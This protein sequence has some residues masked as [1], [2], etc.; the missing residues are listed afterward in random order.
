MA[1]RLEVDNPV[2][3]LIRIKN[4]DEY[5]ISKVIDDDVY[6]R[7]CYELRQ[8]LYSSRGM[9]RNKR[10]A[11]QAQ[12]RYSIPVD[13]FAALLMAGDPDALAWQNDKNDRAALHRMVA[14]FPHWKVAG[15]GC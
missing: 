1:S 7:R 11:A 4:G 3:T 8:Q 12:F 2:Q 5:T 6:R 14:R 9:I 13:E 10:G 15:S